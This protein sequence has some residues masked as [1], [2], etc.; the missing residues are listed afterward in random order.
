MTKQ[1]RKAKDPAPD[2]DSANEPGTRWGAEQAPREEAVGPDSVWVAVPRA[3]VAAQAVAADEEDNQ[4][5]NKE[6]YY[7]KR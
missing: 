7:A 3:A 4:T 1:G 6:V 5:R 2:G